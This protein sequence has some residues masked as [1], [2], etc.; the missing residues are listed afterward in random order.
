MIG[1]NP[2]ADIG[3]HPE[4]QKSKILFSNSEIDMRRNTSYLIN[5]IFNVQYHVLIHIITYITYF[6]T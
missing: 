5:N 1:K 4:S 3:V 2:E 6:N